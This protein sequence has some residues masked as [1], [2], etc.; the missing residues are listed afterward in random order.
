MYT[1]DLQDSIVKY[2]SSNEEIDKKG[3][4]YSEWKTFLELHNKKHKNDSFAFEM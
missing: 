2:N 3:F 1:A 4:N